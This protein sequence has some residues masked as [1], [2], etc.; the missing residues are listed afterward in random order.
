MVEYRDVVL[1]QY[2]SHALSKHLC[3]SRIYIAVPKL[4]IPVK[5]NSLYSTLKSQTYSMRGHLAILAEILGS[6]QLFWHRLSSLNSKAFNKIQ[7]IL[8]PCFLNAFTNNTMITDSKVSYCYLLSFGGQDSGLVLQLKR[9]KSVSAMQP[10][11]PT[12]CFKIDKRHSCGGDLTFWMISGVIPTCS[13]TS[14]GSP[15]TP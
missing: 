8:R 1:L 14:M 2:I 12:L 9:G 5:K 10:K 7:I 11:Q 4:T 6:D 3:C 13:L 15:P